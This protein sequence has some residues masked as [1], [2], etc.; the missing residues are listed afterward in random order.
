MAKRNI[1]PIA[2]THSADFDGMCSAALLKKY[3]NSQIEIHPINYGDKELKNTS[4]FLDAFNLKGRDVYVCDF[5]FNPSLFK[6]IIDL[7]NQTIWLDHHV[8]A[9]KDVVDSSWYQKMLNDYYTNP[10]KSEKDNL[11]EK[12]SGIQCERD[13]LPYSGAYLTWAWLF[14]SKD[15]G[16]AIGHQKNEET[17]KWERVVENIP[18]SENAYANEIDFQISDAWKRCPNFIK[19]IAACDTFRFDFDCPKDQADIQ[20]FGMK[21]IGLDNNRYDLWEALLVDT[22]NDEA[23]S[24]ELVEK[25]QQLQEIIENDGRAVLAYN[26]LYQYPKVMKA[27]YPIKLKVNGK[28][29]RGLALN[30]NGFNSDIFMSAYDPEKTD[31]FIDYNYDNGVWNYGVYVPEDKKEKVSAVDIVRSFDENGG[32]HVGAAGGRTEKLLKELQQ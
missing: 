12:F 4:A 27:A 6:K 23:T 18:I 16:L 9:I 26:V 8:S 24:Y 29:F 21:A 28:N 20:Q 14:N 22:D 3:F 2:F 7:S 31:F 11:F 5:S 15:A 17:G 25:K 30:T 1:L 13:D 19:N 10:E 32:G